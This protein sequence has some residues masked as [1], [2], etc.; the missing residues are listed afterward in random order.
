MTKRNDKGKFDAEFDAGTAARARAREAGEVLVAIC[1]DE[2]GSMSSIAEATVSAFNEYVQSLYTESLKGGPAMFVTLTQFSDPMTRGGE[3]ARVQYEALRLDKVPTLSAKTY[4]PNGN[5]PLYDAIGH[6]IRSAEVWQ[7]AELNRRVLLVIQ[8]DGY[9]NASRD[10]TRL[11]IV[12][13]IQRN[14]NHGSWTAI[15]LGAG[16][17]AWATGQTVGIRTAGNT[18]TYEHTASSSNAAGVRLAKATHYYGATGQGYVDSAA[19]LDGAFSSTI[20]PEEEAEAEKKP[21]RWA[22]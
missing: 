9:E 11:E 5:T 10:F 12:N 3:K 4:R 6:T 20:T 7:E 1:L 16:I 13:L 15:M 8:T 18:V 14:E 17:D 2:S 21:K 19:T 22:S